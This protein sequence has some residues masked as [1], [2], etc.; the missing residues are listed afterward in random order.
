MSFNLLAF[1]LMKRLGFSETFLYPLYKG[2]Y[3][4]QSLLKYGTADMFRSVAL[5]ISTR[6]NRQCSYCPNSLIKV[7]DNL[8]PDEVF[9]KALKDLAAIKYSGVVYYHRYNEP[10]LDPSLVRKIARVTKTLPRVLSRVVTN[11]D[12]LS[13][14]LLAQLVDAGMS[15]MMVTLHSGGQK[16]AEAVREISAEYAS[17]VTVNSIDGVDLSNRSGL[18]DVPVKR[19]DR[20]IDPLTSL[21]IGYNGVIILCCDDYRRSVT[22]GSIME[23]SVMQIW[24]DPRFVR[25]RSDLGKGVVKLEMCR[26]CLGLE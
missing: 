6:C 22:F 15:Q 16:R 25:L 23:R 13:K 9:E 4:T 19:R 2:F 24:Q 11:G 21:Q 5:E 20:C 14:D 1:N 17:L 10:L 12:F 18:L 3:A 7:P 8:M 26:K